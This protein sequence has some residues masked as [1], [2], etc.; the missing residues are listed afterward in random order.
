[1][2][3]IQVKS[4][5]LVNASPENI[6][7]ALIDYVNK[8]PQ[9]LTANFMDYS[10][11]KG[12]HGKGTIIRYRLHAANR[13]RDYRLRIDEP[14][15]GKIITE[16]D[17]NSTLVNTWTLAAANSGTRVSVITEWEGGHGVKGFFERTFA[18]M[19]VKSIYSSVLDALDQLVSN[20][21]AN[22]ANRSILKE[23]EKRGVSDRLGLLVLVLS[24]VVGV[25]F[26][27]SYFQKNHA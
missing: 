8:R 6:Y 25:A 11:E 16:Q 23:E 13:E 26:L 20:D 24:S 19:G 15:K 17:T 27:I 10:V 22:S 18:P 9:I 12:G 21:S 5:R 7:A 3:H 4:E 1:M 14:V 2:A